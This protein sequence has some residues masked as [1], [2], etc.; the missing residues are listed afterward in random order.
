M[1]ANVLQAG[2]KEERTNTK[3]L[4]F[5]G[6][7]IHW[8]EYKGDALP[9]LCHIWLEEKPWIQGAQKCLTLIP[10]VLSLS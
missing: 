1:L 5:S 7:L 9:G 3:I 6:H 8:S 2:A 4:V 10:S